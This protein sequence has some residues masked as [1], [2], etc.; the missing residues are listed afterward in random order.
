MVEAGGRHR[1]GAGPA[2]RCRRRCSAP[3]VDTETTA[4][5]PGS[6]RRSMKPRSVASS[7][8]GSRGHDVRQASMVS[9][10]GR[11]PG[12]I[13]SSRS[14]I[15]LSTVCDTR[16]CSLATARLDRERT[17]NHRRTPVVVARPPPAEA[18]CR[19]AYESPGDARSAQP[20]GAGSPPRLH[21]PNCVGWR[22]SEALEQSGG[23]RSTFQHR[24]ADGN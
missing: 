14:R 8:T 12:P 7:Q 6:L 1:P 22:L 17:A 24:Q 11:W 18:P 13:H 21:E 9:A 23:T 5:W 19:A 2:G 10:Y 3:E 15:R 4:T 16:R 20:R